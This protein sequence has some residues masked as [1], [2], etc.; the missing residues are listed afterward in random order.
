MAELVLVPVVFEATESQETN[1]ESKS[2]D[3]RIN[4]SIA[5]GTGIKRACVLQ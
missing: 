1:F 5:F 4:I 3:P 2:F